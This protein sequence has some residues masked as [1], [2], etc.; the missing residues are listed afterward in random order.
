MV[1]L[2]NVARPVIK[3]SNLDFLGHFDRRSVA[4]IYFV[5][6]YLGILL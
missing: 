6:V 1:V 5:S 4:Y 2:V 3:L